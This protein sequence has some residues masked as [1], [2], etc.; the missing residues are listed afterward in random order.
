MARLPLLSRASWAVSWLLLGALIVFTVIRVLQP[1]DSQVVVGVAAI[2]PWPYFLAWPV[3]ALSMA[4][5]HWLMAALALA[6]VTVQV[7]LV[8][9]TWRPDVSAAAPVGQWRLR[10]FDANVRYN[11]LDLSGIAKE[12]DADDPDVVTLEE[13]SNE[14][15]NSL[16]QTGA[17]AQYPWHFIHVDPGSSGF[18]VWSRVPLADPAIWYAGSH[19][20]VT[21]TLRPSSGASISLLVVHTFAPIGPGEPAAWSEEL[22]EIAVRAASDSRPLI[23]VGD[24]NAT[25]DMKQFTGLLHTGLD[26][27]AVERGQGWHMTWPRGLVVPPFV[28]PD[29]LLYSDG[30]TVTGYRLGHGSGSDH[31]PLVVD[32]ARAS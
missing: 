30:L 7:I 27:A 17:V 31:R 5:Q 10:I 26:D 4:R 32:L 20:E 13:L 6:L 16:L 9:P 2:T 14:N 11:N 18:G 15:V 3:A 19:P 12:I 28:R 1:G 23:V 29:H 24:F 22:H 8:L 21:A 25:N